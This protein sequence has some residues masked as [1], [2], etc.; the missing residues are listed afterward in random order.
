MHRLE[1]PVVSAIDKRS[2]DI[3]KS[4]DD[5]VF[6]SYFNPKDVELKSSFTTLASRN[7]H[8]FT[9]GTVSDAA[10]ARAE[11]VPLGCIVR[12][13]TEEEPKTLCGQSRLDILQEFVEKSTVPLIGEMTRRNE[14]KYLQVSA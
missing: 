10:L 13:S 14:L 6:I 2:L 9:F 8:R 1:R 4:V 12:Y 11:N 3:L 5:A 7:H